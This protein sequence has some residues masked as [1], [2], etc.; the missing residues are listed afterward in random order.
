MDKEIST[1]EK[2]A[3]FANDEA[4]RIAKKYQIDYIEVI[5]EDLLRRWKGAI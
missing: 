1:Y 4:N 2:W 3:E 5:F